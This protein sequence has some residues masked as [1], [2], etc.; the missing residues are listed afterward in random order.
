MKWTERCFSSLRKSSIPV[1]TIVVDNGST[2]ETQDYVKANFPE[3]DFIQSKENLGFG[4]ANNLGIEKAFKEGADFFYLM[5]QDAW[6]FEDSI[7]KMIDVYNNYPNKNEVG[8]L[9]PMHLDGTEQ[10]FD[11]HFEMYLSRNITENRAFS[12][13]FCGHPKPFYEMI[14]VNAAHWFI[15]KQTIEEVGGF[16]PYFFQGV[17]DHEYANRV[18]FKNKKFFI[19]THSMVVHDAKKGFT[20]GDSAENIRKISMRAQ[21]ES[22]YMNPTFNYNISNEKKRFYSDIIKNL[23]KG[24]VAEGKFYQDMFNYFK[25]RFQQIETDRKIAMTEKHPFLNL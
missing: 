5:N 11:Q 7:Q 24:N 1:K 20:R 10:Q 15:P 9:S 25:P 17:E 6:I 12:D 13:V 22:Q 4:K 23:M 16:N 14:F 19:C 2:D 8:I 3:V 21:R 18:K